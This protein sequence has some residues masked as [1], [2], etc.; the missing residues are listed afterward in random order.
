MDIDLS[1]LRALER[2]RDLSLDVLV[3]AI[4][5]A[6]LV[7]YHRTEGSHRLARVELDRKTGHVVVWAREEGPLIPAVDESERP[8]SSQQC[9]RSKEEVRNQI[10]PAAC[11][12]AT[13][14]TGDP[15]ANVGTHRG[16]YL[17][18]AKERRVADDKVERCRQIGTR[19]VST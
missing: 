9:A 11:T 3:A 2:E 14:H 1:A 8:T 5:Q 7:A 17:H 12:L 13:D 19:K 10:S 4:E 16:R 15:I 6:L 18:T